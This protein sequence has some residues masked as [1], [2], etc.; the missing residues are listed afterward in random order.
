MGKT[1]NVERITTKEISQLIQYIADEFPEPMENH[2][3]YDMVSNIIK[4]AA[5]NF[6]RNDA[7]YHIAE[8]IPEVSTD[9]LAPVLED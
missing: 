3:T 6:A 4:Y 2:F 5:K 9:E 7:L 1:Y 8:I